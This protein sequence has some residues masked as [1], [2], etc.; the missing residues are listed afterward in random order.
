MKTFLRASILLAVLGLSG[1]AFAQDPTPKCGAVEALLDGVCIH[2]TRCPA[3]VAEDGARCAPV[4]TCAE[5]T[6]WVKFKKRCVKYGEECG[7]GS[8][9]VRTKGRCVVKGT[10]CGAGSRWIEAKARCVVKG[11]ECK[12]GLLWVPRVGRCV[13]KGTECGRG[14]MWDSRVERCRVL[15]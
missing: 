8:R 5:G 13:V 6:H 12:E 15:K 3:G 14:L 9:W 7:A 11:A 4:P 10:E 1:S 2:K